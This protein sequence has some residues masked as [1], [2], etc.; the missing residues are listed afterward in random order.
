MGVSPPHPHLSLE[1]PLTATE[2]TEMIVYEGLVGLGH[3]EDV[4]TAH[5]LERMGIVQLVSDPTVRIGEV[6]M[7]HIVS[8]QHD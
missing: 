8:T 1:R 7:P 6:G 3:P 4:L 5:V 2:M